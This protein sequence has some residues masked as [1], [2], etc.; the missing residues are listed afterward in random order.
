MLG[1]GMTVSPILPRACFLV[2][3][4]ENQAARW[5]ARPCV[6]G[7]PIKEHRRNGCGVAVPLSGESERE[8]YEQGGVVLATTR[9]P[10]GHGSAGFARAAQYGRR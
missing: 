6:V 1:S 3:P 10:A 4:V 2:E 7:Q 9:T 8:A 5:I